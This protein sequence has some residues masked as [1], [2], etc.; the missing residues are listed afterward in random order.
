MRSSALASTLLC[1]LLSATVAGCVDR[2][3]DPDARNG[4]YPL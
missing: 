2:W 1:L 4:V 3:S